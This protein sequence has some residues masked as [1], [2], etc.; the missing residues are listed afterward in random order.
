MLWRLKM[1]SN[2]LAALL[3]FMAL[4]MA[5]NV[6]A[7]VKVPT[8]ATD[9]VKVHQVGTD[10]TLWRIATNNALEGVSVWQLLISI[11]QLNGHAFA[12]ND[13]SQLR[14]GS[15]LILP[16]V[17]QLTDLNP[18]QAEKFF[19]QLLEDKNLL[20]SI[21]QTSE[22]QA[23][24]KIK[25]QVTHRV[26]NGETLWRI[27]SNNTVEGVSVWQTLISIYQ[28]NLDAFLNNDVTKLRAD[29]KLV[30]PTLVQATSLSPELAQLTYQRLF[31]ASLASIAETPTQSA[32]LSTNASQKVVEQ[33][34]ATVAKQIAASVAEQI[35]SKVAGQI[36][37]DVAASVAEKIVA[38]VAQSIAE[39]I[40]LSVTQMEA[41]A[42][43]TV[44][45]KIADNVSQAVEEVVDKE[46]ADTVAEGANDDQTG[47]AFVLKTVTITGNESFKTQTLH[48]LVADAEGTEQSIGQL[49]QLATRIT[50]FYQDQGYSVVRAI[51]PAQTVSDGNVT[52]QVVEAKYGQV[53][54]T[55]NS[56][57][58]DSLLEDTIAPMQAG[59]VISDDNLYSSLLHLSDVPGV[60]VNSSLSPGAGVGTSDVTLIVADDQAYTASLTLDQ[61]GDDYTGKERITA[62]VALNNLVGHGDVL[63]VSG[64]VSSGDM[65]Y[66]R[67]AYDWLLNGDGTHV[68]AAYSGVNY[69]LGKELTSTQANGSTRTSSIWA[70]H[71]LQRS[72]DANASVQLQYDV[73]QLQDHIDSASLQTDR[74]ISSVSV[75]ASGD[76]RNNYKRGGVS[77]WNFGFKSGDVSFDNS[78]A[79]GLDASSA[80][81]AGN[82]EKI[83][84]S[85]N[86]L[87]SVSD[88]GSA[89]L[90]ASGQ[91][92]SQNLDSSEKLSAGGVG[93]VRAYGSGAVSGDMGYVASVEFRYY[94]AQAFDGSLNGTLFY[95]A[96]NV[97]VNQ[98]PW[99]NST[100]ENSAAIS[101]AGIALNW[102]GPK[103][104]AGALVLAAP[105][106]STSALVS[107]HPD[108]TLWLQMSK[109][110]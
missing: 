49:G 2:K 70:K 76:R 7:E 50:Q 66:S 55:N 107:E 15:K 4:P 93:A 108:H 64:M 86:H 96:A 84:L 63:S 79:E 98:L 22:P 67:L 28:L 27:A 97:T 43:K 57:V 48:A 105:L 68:G 54:F 3:L 95:D 39:Q 62:N 33:I 44:A 80:K 8:S 60:I 103:Q 75:T 36:A 29:S 10:E 101:G 109:G 92:A 56:S 77:S 81:T 24:L 40:A 83:N 51:L 30:M 71:P 104:V 20:V 11:Y 73:N 91:W 47:T 87:Q 102:S 23:K 25:K 74:T 69:R 14:V 35:A 58:S 89:Y 110:F 38:S 34:A 72:L 26:S 90:S 1:N 85:L 19:E 78:A 106:N 82:F 45:Q 88:K 18:A 53:N 100:G 42:A 6:N 65:Q 61:H 31:V 9:V 46:I 94:L 16:N 21:T 17:S 59:S 99:S 13:I 32:Q 37:A 52:I 41:N 12:H 5:S